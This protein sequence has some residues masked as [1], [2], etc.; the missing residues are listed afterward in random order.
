MSPDLE[1]AQR[2]IAAE[3]GPDVGEFTPSDDKHFFGL[4]AMLALAG[5]FLAG[6]FEGFAKEAGEK[7][8]EKLGGTLIDFISRKIH[9]ERAKPV[10]EQAKSLD[11]AASEAKLCVLTP[12]TITAISAAVEKALASVLAQEAEPDIAD[13]VAARVRQEAL[14][15]LVQEA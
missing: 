4:A 8:G 11:A 9:S 12:E 3:I 5:S 13:R 1:Q 7:C 14:R 10:D 6:F 2:A 15:V